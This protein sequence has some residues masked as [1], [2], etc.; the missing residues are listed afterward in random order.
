MEP[1]IPLQLALQVF[2]RAEDQ[3]LD[4]RDSRFSETRLTL[5]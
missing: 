2:G 5:Q 4:E 1:R 3:G